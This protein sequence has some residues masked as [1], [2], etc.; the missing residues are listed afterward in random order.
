MQLKRAKEIGIAGTAIE[1]TTNAL[2]LGQ[3]RLGLRETQLKIGQNQ[4]K[5]GREN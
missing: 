2:V 3:V 4:L 5:D 1:I